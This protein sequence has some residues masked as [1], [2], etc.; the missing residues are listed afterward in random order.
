[1]VVKKYL[2][3]AFVAMQV[4]DVLTTNHFIATG[5]GIEGNPFV[6]MLM[7]QFG[8]WWWVAKLGIVSFTIPVLARGRTRYAAIMTGLYSVVIVNNIML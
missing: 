7:V 8:A 1:M 4:L 5:R 2:L 6:L 3:A